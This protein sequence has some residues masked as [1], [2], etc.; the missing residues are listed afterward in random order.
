[1]NAQVRQA[2]TG[3][4]N[5]MPDKN[6]PTQNPDES[7]PP[8]YWSRLLE[9]V[10]QT[11]DEATFSLLHAHFSPLIR[12][13]FMAKGGMMSRDTIEELVQ[14]VMMKVW[15]KADSF[16]STKAAASTWIF[17]LARNIRIDYLRKAIRHDSKTEP[18]TTDE[19]WEEDG[20]NQ[21]FVYLHQSR[22]ESL[23]RNMLRELPLEQSECLQ[24]VYI[25]GKS[26]SEI[27]D[28]LSLPLGTVK[29][30]VRLGIRR[31][32]ANFDRNG[33]GEQ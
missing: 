14:E 6:M 32:Q 25:E 7:H 31:L 17:T 11:R 23:M 1:M 33:G 20:V 24:K 5:A 27:S 21:P 13:F 3:G 30:R 16:D 18:L 9:T 8:K 15:F 10:A 22:T 12:N 2:E 19:I 28:E 4:I 26:H 29:S